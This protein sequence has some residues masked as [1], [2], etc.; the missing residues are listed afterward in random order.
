MKPGRNRPKPKEASAKPRVSAVDA[1]GQAGRERAQRGDQRAPDD[2]LARAERELRDQPPLGEQRR[3]RAR[4]QHDRDPLLGM[5]E[6]QLEPVDD[7][8]ADHAQ[9]R[10][11]AVAADHAGHQPGQHARVAP[12]QAA[13]RALLGGDRGVAAADRGISDDRAA[14]VACAACRR[15]AAAPARRG[16]ARRSRRRRSAAR[17]GRAA[18]R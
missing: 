18:G 14:R 15:A 16:P 8:E 10:R 2:E 11:L 12:A 13:R 1:A 17:R 5:V 6:R 4:H 3:A 9:S 7:E